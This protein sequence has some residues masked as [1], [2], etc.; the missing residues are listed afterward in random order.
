M[1][2]IYLLKT[3]IRI[4]KNIVIDQDRHR[5]YIDSFG[6]WGEIKSKS[7]L[8]KIGIPQSSKKVDKI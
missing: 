8:I 5:V 4:D 2:S 6:L 3:L 1:V 7:K